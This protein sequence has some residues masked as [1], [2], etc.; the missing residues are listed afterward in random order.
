MAFLLLII[1]PCHSPNHRWG[2][3]VHTAAKI[4]AELLPHAVRRCA[5]K[6]QLLALRIEAACQIGT[7]LLLIYLII[8]FL[9][10]RGHKWEHAVLDAAII[11][12]T[13]HP[14]DVSHAPPEALCRLACGKALHHPRHPPHRKQLRQAD[15]SQSLLASTIRQ[16]T[17]SSK[18]AMQM[19]SRYACEMSLRRQHPHATLRV[20]NPSIRT[21]T[22][23]TVSSCI[24]GS[25]HGVMCNRT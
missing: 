10:F 25:T 12:A 3:E 20:A 22:L 9:V 5:A 17:T 7:C 21:V 18:L 24:T 13:P 1:N 23:P 8:H 19:S 6:C 15:T 11:V 14:C 16:E 2:N 4:T